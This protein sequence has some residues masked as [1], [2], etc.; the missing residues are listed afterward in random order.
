MTTEQNKEKQSSELEAVL[1]QLSRD[2][3]RFIVARQEFST[4]KEAAES[5]GIKPNTVSQW[6]TKKVPI[7]KAARLMA[8]DGL[9]TAQYIRRRNLAKAMAV[10]VSGLDSDGEKVRQDVASEIIEWEMG[11]A[12]Q[13]NEHG[14]HDGG[15]IPVQL[16]GIG[17]ID[18]DTDI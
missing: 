4:D 10:K 6:K 3:I 14:G 5:I 2:Q 12:M 7:D 1:A 18:P 9:V 11:K 17:G 8:L 13:R 15:P 16:I